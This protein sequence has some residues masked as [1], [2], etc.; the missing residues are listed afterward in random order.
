MYEVYICSALMFYF[1]FLRISS[2]AWEG[3]QS[4][5]PSRHYQSCWGSSYPSACLVCRKIRGS[6]V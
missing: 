3:T 5:W 1:E 4:T 6:N 2:A